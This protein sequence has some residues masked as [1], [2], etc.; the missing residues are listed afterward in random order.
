MLVFGVIS[1]LPLFNSSG[2]CL[3]NLLKSLPHA[4]A[5]FRLVLLETIL[6][7][8]ITNELFI[9]LSMK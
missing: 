2:K 3:L 4:I 5:L 9:S 7:R 8:Q 6:F 1:D